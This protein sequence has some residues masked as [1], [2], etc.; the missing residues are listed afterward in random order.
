[1]SRITVT[2]GQL[3]ALRNDIRKQQNE[4]PAFYYFNKSRTD[5]FFS[6]NNMAL[7]VLESRMDEFVKKYV[8]LD[9]DMQPMT[10]DVDGQIVY[11]FYSPD[12]K[13]KYLNA[14]N[15]FLA[16]KISIDL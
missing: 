3:M 5:K 1:M 12:Y 14:V 9:A 16:I 4:S 2:Y 7:K 8:K 11:Q 15:K 13:E 6:L 10:E